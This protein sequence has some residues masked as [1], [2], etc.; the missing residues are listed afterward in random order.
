MSACACVFLYASA[1]VFLRVCMLV[2]ARLNKPTSESFIIALV[3]AVSLPEGNN[4]ETRDRETHG[5]PLCTQACH[6]PVPS[7]GHTGHYDVFQ[8]DTSVCFPGKESAQSR[9]R[10]TNKQSLV[11]FYLFISAI[12]GCLDVMM[13]GIRRHLWRSLR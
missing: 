8:M 5:G 12:A 7:G 1:Y 11:E 4:V 10:I 3:R 13:H 2:C 9:E 6:M